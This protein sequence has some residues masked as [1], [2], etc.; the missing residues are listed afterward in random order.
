MGYFTNLKRRLNPARIA[1]YVARK[2]GSK[3]ADSLREG[4]F[5]LLVRGVYADADEFRFVQVGGF[6]GVSNDYLHEFLVSH[7][8]RGV[9][10][11]PQQEAFKNLT[12]AY[13]DHPAIAMCRAAIA[14]TPGQVKLYK[15]AD[16]F[17]YAPSGEPVPHSIA[18]LD[19]RHPVRYMRKNAEWLPAKVKDEE[20]LAWE[21]VDALD[22]PSVLAKYDLNELELLFVDAEGFDGEVVRQTLSVC[23]PLVINYEHKSL[24]RRERQALWKLLENNGY[25]LTTH[26]KDVGDTLAVLPARS[27]ST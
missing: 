2:L 20:L 18:S 21:L 3:P 22:M 23:K 8:V 1:D 7:V 10:L 12:A 24:P 13:R 27:I 14:S 15:I 6:D 9:I 5:G 19:P 17:R 4:L 25:S 16:D 26:R 11:E